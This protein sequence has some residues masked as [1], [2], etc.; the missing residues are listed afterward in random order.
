[1]ESKREFKGIWIP[2]EIWEESKLSIMEKIMLAEIDSFESKNGCFASNSFFGKLLKLTPG[3][4]SQMITKL[5]KMEYIEVKI[6]YKFH[7]KEVDRR[8][9]KLRKDKI[10]GRDTPI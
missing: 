6:L 9:M 2:K 7:S 3:R 1:M 5:K 4:I 8:I 10:Y